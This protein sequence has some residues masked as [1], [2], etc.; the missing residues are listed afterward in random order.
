[1]VTLPK[2]KF[3]E[4]LQG[5]MGFMLQ[6]KFPSNQGVDLRMGKNG[7]L[8]IYSTYDGPTSRKL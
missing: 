3:K 8:L 6:N 5:K 4:F 1:M 2:M 7:L